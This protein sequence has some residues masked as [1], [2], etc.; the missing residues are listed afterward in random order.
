MAAVMPMLAQVD[1]LDSQRE[2]ELVNHEA[3][4][5]DLKT[6]NAINDAE[7]LSNL[8]GKVFD[9]AVETLKGEGHFVFMKSANDTWNGVVQSLAD[10]AKEAVGE[11]DD[12][13]RVKLV[14]LGAAAPVYLQL[15]QRE[16]Q[17]RMDL[18]KQIQTRDGA[19][20]KIGGSDTTETKKD[21][22]EDKGK[23]M[24]AAD[25]SKQVAASMG[26]K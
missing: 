24:S 10:A 4:L 6:D 25:M 20:A 12:L 14:T 3:T 17:M 15:Y 26:Q 5:K 21:T 1:A 13:E 2:A 16:R 18:E 19:R 23:P 8:R 7:N 22:T 9:A 11:T